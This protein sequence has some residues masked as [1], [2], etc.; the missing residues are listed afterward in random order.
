MINKK[1][2]L[3]QIELSNLL[4][5]K[6]LLIKSAGFNLNKYL[7]IIV[8]DTTINNIDLVKKIH[9]MNEKGIE[10]KYILKYLLKKTNIAEL[11]LL[12]NEYELYGKINKELLSIIL[13][14]NKYII[15]HLINKLNL[16]FILII[17]LLYPFPIVLI[18][19]SFF[20]KINLIL[21]MILPIMLVFLIITRLNKNEE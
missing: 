10:S 8:K 12:L 7:K 15:E 18:L 4:L 19:I 5:L 16:F 13:E 1:N 6:L 11:K 2:F 14:R 9:E 17:A 3:Y 21:L 20:F